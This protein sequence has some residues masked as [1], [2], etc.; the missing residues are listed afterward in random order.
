MFHTHPGVGS[1]ASY[2]SETDIKLAAKLNVPSYIGVT[3]TG[4]IH[5]FVA[6]RDKITYSVDGQLSLGEIL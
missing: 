6:G 2:F 5:Q 4:E 1:L 3:S